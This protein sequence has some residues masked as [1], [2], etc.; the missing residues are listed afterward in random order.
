[1]KP[2]LEQQAI[3]DVVAS[4]EDNILVQALAGAAKTTMLQLISQH[5]S[6]T[7]TLCLAFNKAIADDMQ[8]KMGSLTRCQTLNSLGHQVLK[9]KLGKRLVISGRKCTG[10][11]HAC[12][13]ENQ[14]RGKKDKGLWRAFNDMNTAIE[15]GKSCGWIPDREESLMDDGQFFEGLDQ[16]FSL[17]EQELIKLVSAKSY[18]MAHKGKIDFADQL[19]IPAVLPCVFP[20]YPLVLVDEAQDFSSL[21]HIL[22]RKLARKRLIAVGDENQSIYGFRGAHMYSMDELQSMFNMKQMPLTISFRCPQEVVKE[23]WSKVPS[24]SW[25]EDA[26]IGK[27]ERWGKWRLDDIP[28]NA[29]IICR[30]NSPLY[31]LGLRLLLSGRVPNIKGG[32][33]TS[34]ISK[35]MVKFGDLSMS[36]DELLAHIDAW[37]KTKIKTVLRKNAASSIKDKADCMRVFALQGETLEEALAYADA[38]FESKGRI[39]LMTGHKA[40]GMEFD[41]VFFLDMKLIGSGLQEENLRYVIQ[42]RTRNRLVY[43]NS[44]DQEV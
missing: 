1:M 23:V 16:E 35:N 9:Q 18:N 33:I 37:E 2:T 34:F 22:L 3:L 25:K 31:K 11:L 8:T 32:A 28:N 20:Q 14:S 15:Q 4:T 42:T 26:I 12:I 36:R 21:N 7:P 38:L 43:F 29:V 24:M 10:L 44:K 39:N 5:L 41:E 13:K 27:V 17:Q 6:S 19:L 30:N 40:K